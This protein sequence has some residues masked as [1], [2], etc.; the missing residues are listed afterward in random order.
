[1][2][3]Q[4]LD[5]KLGHLETNFIIGFKAAA[6]LARNH[7]CLLSTPVTI[8]STTIDG[9][10]LAQFLSNESNKAVSVDEFSKA[11]VRTLIRESIETITN[12][13][14]STNQYSKLEFD[15]TFNFARII[16]NSFA[17][18]YVL[19]LTSFY[20]KILANRDIEWNGKAIS[21]NMDGDSLEKTFFR[22][23]DAIDL[24][25]DLR[26]LCRSTFKTNSTS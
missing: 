6:F 3:F 8:D 13:A 15:D 23:K 18:D 21:L 4:M 25:H 10:G 22:Y 7:E 16:R 2:D 14:N 12:Y 20:K 24:F 19:S 11:H 17:H 1:M 26:K 9:T 5:N